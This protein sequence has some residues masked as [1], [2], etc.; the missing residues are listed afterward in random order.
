MNLK[1]IEGL[2]LK[3]TI[4]SQGVPHKVLCGNQRLLQQQGIDLNFN[5]FKD[6]VDALEREGNT[7]VCFTVDDQVRLLISLA[8]T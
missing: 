2:G 7:V 5:R 8:E 4:R 6:N 3:A 1:F